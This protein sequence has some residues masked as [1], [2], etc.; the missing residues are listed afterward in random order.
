MNVQIS[1]LVLGEEDRLRV[2]EI[3]VLRRIVRSLREAVI[4]SRSRL[5][6]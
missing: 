2:Y 5:R 4:G 3:R 1:S 6:M